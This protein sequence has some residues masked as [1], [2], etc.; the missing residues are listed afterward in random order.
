MGYTLHISQKEIDRHA[1]ALLKPVKYGENSIVL[2]YP[3]CFIGYTIHGFMEKPALLKKYLGAYYRKYL[4]IPIEC[5]AQDTSD[6][7]SQKAMEYISEEADRKL[8]PLTNTLSG[9]TRSLVS[10]GLDP[11]FYL[12]NTH[13]LS[14]DT[15][16]SVLDC[17]HT[18]VTDVPRAGVTIC[19]EAN[20]Y[21]DAYRNLLQKYH[22]LQHTYAVIPV[23]SE[24]ESAHFIRTLALSWDMKLSETYIQAIIRLCGGYLWLLREAVRSIRDESLSTTP[25]ILTHSKILERAEYIIS[26]LDTSSLH[27]MRM[28]CENPEADVPSDALQYF[29][30]TGMIQKRNGKYAPSGTIFLETLHRR[31]KRME[32]TIEGSAITYNQTVIN[33]VLSPSE[34]TIL[35]TL[36][37]HRGTIVSRNDIATAMWGT[38]T[39]IKYSDWAID[40]AISRIR[41]TLM[42]IGLPREMITTKKR[43][44]FLL[45]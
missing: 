33:H 29:T 5:T 7:I 45:R 6:S 35:H 8:T 26:L 25:D 14:F 17:F 27:G 38:Q 2:C 32:L 10:H 19:T 43:Q 41:K 15:F 18:L 11:Y 20:I 37:T 31:T 3:G 21:S 1:N 44:G 28:L 22:R 9:L 39:D 24:Q 12:I 30:T 40:K 23:F 36:L 16:S 4:L 34:L 42:T 13:L